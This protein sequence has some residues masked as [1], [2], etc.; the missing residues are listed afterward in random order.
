MVAAYQLSEPELA[1]LNRLP[2]ARNSSF[3]LAKHRTYRCDV[4]LLTA[5]GM[6]R[7]AARDP[8]RPV[9][10]LQNRRSVCG[11]VKPAR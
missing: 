1:K 4:P 5:T 10:I 11:T 6:S 3:K 2:Y 8:D 9:A 7:T